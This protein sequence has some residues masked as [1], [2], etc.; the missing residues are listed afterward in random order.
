MSRNRKSLE[1]F[2]VLP[3]IEKPVPLRY[4]RGEVDNMAAKEKV[5]LWLDGERVAH[6]D[7]R[8]TCQRESHT[9]GNAVVYVS[10]AREMN[11]L[12]SDTEGS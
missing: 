11:G 10:P 12:C 8:V 2:D 1:S 7:G 9:A 3:V 4:L 5:V 6:E